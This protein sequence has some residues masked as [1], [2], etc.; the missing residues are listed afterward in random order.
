MLKLW[1]DH[2]QSFYDKAMHGFQH[3][4]TKINLFLNLVFYILI[5]ACLNFPELKTELVI[6][7]IL[8]FT[9]GDDREFRQKHNYLI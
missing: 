1:R 6:I 7:D 2:G 4:Y 8:L 3:C 5:E 9:K